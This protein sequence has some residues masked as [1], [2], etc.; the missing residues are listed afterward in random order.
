V[1]IPG[2][3]REQAARGKKQSVVDWTHFVRYPITKEDRGAY[4]F[5]GK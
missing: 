4:G 2:T 5:R 1:F 3:V